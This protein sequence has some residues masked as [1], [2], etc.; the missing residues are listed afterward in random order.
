MHDFGQFPPEDILILREVDKAIAAGVAVPRWGWPIPR[1]YNGS[2]GS[3]RIAGWQKLRIAQRLGLVLRA[4]VCA[5]CKSAPATQDHVEIYGRCLV[6][7][8]SCRSCHFRVHR[9]FS[10]PGQWR[11]LMRRRGAGPDWVTSLRMIE[12]TREEAMVVAA[13]PDI[14][15]ALAAS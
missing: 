15:A 11:A 14:F 12:L 7:I 10:D 5:V 2:L 1:A 4:H 6:S 13:A 9:R 3:E 8:P